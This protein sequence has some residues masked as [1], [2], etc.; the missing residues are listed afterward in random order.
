MEQILQQISLTLLLGIVSGLIATFLTLFIRL[1]W[2]KIVLPW[3]EE[4]LYQDARIEGRWD[5]EINFTDGDTSHFTFHLKRTSHDVSGEMVAKESGKLYSLRGEFHNMILTLTYCSTV[6]Q[7]VDRGCFTF[8][9]KQNGRQ[10]DGYGAFYYSPEHRIDS[11]PIK[12]FR[13]E[14]AVLVNAEDQPKSEGFLSPSGQTEK[15]TP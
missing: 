14:P 13:V 2:N 12:L 5:G 3:Y 6:L 8:L 10:L 11:A 9:L 15:I 1:Y 4:R 7:A